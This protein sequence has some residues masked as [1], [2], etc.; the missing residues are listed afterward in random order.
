MYNAHVEQNLGRVCNILKLL[1]CVV[2]LVVVV[3]RQ[4][5]DPGLDFLE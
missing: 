4:G 2:K 1:Q 3:P 5:G